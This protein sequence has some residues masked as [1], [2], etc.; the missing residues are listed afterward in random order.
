MDKNNLTEFEQTLL[1]DMNRRAMLI[2]QTE[3]FLRENKITFNKDLLYQLPDD[4]L[5]HLCE[6]WKPANQ[7]NRRKKAKAETFSPGSHTINGSSTKD[8]VSQLT[9]K[10]QSDIMRRILKDVAADYQFDKNNP[11]YLGFLNCSPIDDGWPEIERYVMAV[12]LGRERKLLDSMLAE[13]GLD[14][15]AGADLEEIV[16]I[17]RK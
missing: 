11:D 13:F 16:F 2:I 15:E 5:M 4:T 3:E 1:A 6:T 9:F 14:I 12:F 10:D 7:E 8:K 17:E